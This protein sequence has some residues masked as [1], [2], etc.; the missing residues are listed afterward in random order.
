M[1]STLTSQLVDFII[2]CLGSPTRQAAQSVTLRFLEVGAGTGGTTAELAESLDKL[3]KSGRTKVE[4]VFTDISSTMLLGEFDVIHGTIDVIHGTNCVHATKNIVVTTRHIRQMLNDDGFMALLEITRVVDWLDLVF[5]LLDGWWLSDD[6]RSYPLQSAES[7][8]E[9][10]REAGFGAAMFS[11]GSSEEA[12]TQQL[13]VGCNYTYPGLPDGGFMRKPAASPLFKK[14]TVVYKEVKG[15]QIQADIFFPATTA[16]ARRPMP[17]ALMVH[18]VGYMTLSRQTVRPHQTAH[19]LANGILPVSLDYRLCPEANIVDGAMADVRDAVVRAR[20]SLPSLVSSKSIMVDP[21]QIV[22]IGWSTGGHLAIDARSELLLSIL[23]DPR[24]FA[25][26]LMLNGGLQKGSR[27]VEDLVKEKPSTEGQ[28]SVCPTARLRAGQYKTPTFIIPGDADE[29]A[30]FK[31]AVQFH[32]EMVSRGIKS[33]FLHVK[34]GVH[35][36]DLRLKTET[37]AWEEQVAPG[38]RFLFEVLD[39]D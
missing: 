8:M 25:L 37:K 32:G 38:Y 26:S 33:G 36:H 31:D 21:E 10:L 17:I 34:N 35:I 4:Y 22:V 20:R 1:P 16:P 19:L 5:G 29:L 12:N 2:G 30:M 13:L 27:V 23:I 15:V 39:L 11:R 7:W 28:A 14:E 6:G 24:G 18:G 9:I 3:H